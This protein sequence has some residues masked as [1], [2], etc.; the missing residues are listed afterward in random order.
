MSETGC[1]LFG[2]CVDMGGT[3]SEEVEASHNRL[4]AGKLHDLHN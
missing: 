3:L 2:N 4:I 1:T